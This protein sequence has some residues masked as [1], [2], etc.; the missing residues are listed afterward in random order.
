MSDTWHYRVLPW[1][2]RPLPLLESIAKVPDRQV[3]K[4]G[5]PSI[6]WLLISSSLNHASTIM[7]KGITTV[8]TWKNST[9]HWVL[10]SP[11]IIL[12]ER[13]RTNRRFSG[14]P[15][16]MLDAL[17]HFV[18]IVI[19][20]TE[21]QLSTCLHIPYTLYIPWKMKTATAKVRLYNAKHRSG[22]CM[23]PGEV[24]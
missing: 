5:K 17:H 19:T 10:H 23:L 6:F 15:T 14:N 2:T 18:W 12:N 20:S 3:A 13:T 24:L 11:L 22:I 1:A 8:Q 7:A 21:V 16:L 9:N 4:M